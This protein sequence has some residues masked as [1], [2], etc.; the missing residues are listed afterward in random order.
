MVMNGD[1]L[2]LLMYSHRVF[3]QIIIILR[4]DTKINFCLKQCSQWQY[5][6]KLFFQIV[7]EIFFFFRSK[8][9]VFSLAKVIATFFTK[10]FN[11]KVKIWN[12]ECTER[13]KN[14]IKKNSNN[15]KPEKRKIK[16]CDKQQELV[17]GQKVFARKE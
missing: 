2:L 1:N 17:S 6:T 9:V 16:K 11:Q 5:Y 3:K 12:D 13:N 7:C 10:Q 14:L 8:V 4:C 15:K